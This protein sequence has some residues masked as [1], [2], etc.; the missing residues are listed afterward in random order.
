LK[1]SNKIDV[2]AVIFI[3]SII[4]TNS[5]A[6]LLCMLLILLL[7]SKGKVRLMLLLCSL[8]ILPI[9][10][11]QIQY[12]LTHKLVG[13]AA[14]DGRFN[15]FFNAFQYSLLYPFGIGSVEYTA[16]YKELELGGWDSFSQLVLRYGYQGLFLV[17][18]CLGNI[19]RK[20]PILGVIMW[21]SFFS[22]AI[23]FYPVVCCFYFWSF[24]DA[25]KG[26]S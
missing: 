16:I 3:L 22:Q 23:W 12:H 6:G 9:A 21:L 26:F 25:R 11:Q 15:P 18:L 13:S 20:K 19:T 8:V 4:S 5:T 24:S 10:F 17:I 1:Q 2:Q 14:F 7:S